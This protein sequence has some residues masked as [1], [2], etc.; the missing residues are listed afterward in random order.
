[1]LV[2][3]VVH[4]PDDKHDEVHAQSYFTKHNAAWSHE[5]RAPMDALE[6]LEMGVRKIIARRA[7]LELESSDVVNLGIGMPE[8]IASVAA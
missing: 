7:A 8:G 2:D 5:V 1:M 3:C 6:P 4:I